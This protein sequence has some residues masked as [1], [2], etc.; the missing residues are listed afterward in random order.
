[1]GPPSI[2]VQRCSVRSGLGS[3]AFFQSPVITSL[4]SWVDQCHVGDVLGIFL[5]QPEFSEV[6][7]QPTM[8]VLFTQLSLVLMLWLIGV[9]ADPTRY[10]ILKTTVAQFFSMGKKT[11]WRP[12]S[13]NTFFCRQMAATWT[14]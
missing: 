3:F 14:L 10:N 4:S 12:T 11:S 6:F 5:Y 7:Y 1:M 9:Y 13:C 8:A 2:P